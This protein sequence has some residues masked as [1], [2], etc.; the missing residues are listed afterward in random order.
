VHQVLI[1]D[2][3]FRRYN[4]CVEGKADDPLPIGGREEGVAR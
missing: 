2:A 1:T 4:A 3:F